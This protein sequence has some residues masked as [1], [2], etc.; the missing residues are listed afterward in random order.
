ML[1]IDLT[2]S[3]IVLCENITGGVFS[4]SDK[5]TFENLPN[6]HRF[7]VHSKPS[8]KSF[9]KTEVWLP[10]DWNGIFLGTG[11][12]GMG[13]SI[14]YEALDI[15]VRLGYAVANTDLG[16][17][18]GTKSGFSNPELWKDYGWR[19][20]YL[21]TICA[22]AIIKEFYGKAPD[23]SY[24]LG[25]STGGQQAHSLAQ[26]FPK[27]Y[28]AIFAGVHANNRTHVH[29]YFLWNFI[30]AHNSKGEAL[31]TS[32]D[33]LKIYNCAV[34]FHQLRGDGE[35]GDDFVSCPVTSRKDIA[36]FVNFVS[37]Q[38][39]EY[40]KEQLE[41]LL[42]IYLGPVNPVTKKQIYSGMPIG[43]E[44]YH[45]G[46]GDAISNQPPHNFITKWVFGVDFK[47]ETF[48]FSSDMDKVNSV[49]AAD[50]N[51]NNPDLTE[52]YKN[53]GK[54]L[55]VCGTADACIPFQDAINYYSRVKKCMGEDV[56]NS[57]YRCYIMPGKEHGVIG[58]GTNV[59]WRTTEGG[60]AVDILRH[61]VEKGEAPDML[62]AVGFNGRKAEN[63]IKFKR[64]VYPV[65]N[66]NS[67]FSTK[68]LNQIPL[69]D[70]EY[71]NL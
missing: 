50:L 14:M 67:S 69:C 35:K 39:P 68:E 47:P 52:F 9:I 53:G 59:F 49:L 26:R 63:G 48:N 19:A 34:K 61:W 62:Y 45:A 6:F 46:L 32:D 58:R 43:S 51:A 16:T 54:F 21:M 12:G 2:D 7:V 15:Y 27:E 13:G 17:S 28:N 41:A 31:F 40:T 71:L 3:E 22:K 29:T 57:F 25:G 18:R 4:P 24:F 42:K 10:E 38:I 11:N 30:S 1:K 56:V 33:V 36:E 5:V 70:D 44:I 60:G 55:A 65:D 20:T 66:P 8:E 37:E 23:Y 64:E